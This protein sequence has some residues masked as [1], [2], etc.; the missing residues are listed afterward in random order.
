VV[1]A[2]SVR[3][4]CDEP[5]CGYDDW[6]GAAVVWPSWAAYSTNIRAGYN[7]RRTFDEVGNEVF[8]YMGA[9][10]DGCEVTAVEGITLIIEWERGSETWRETYLQPGDT[11][12]I[13]LVGNENNAMIETIDGY[14][15]FS[16]SL[17]NCDPQPLPG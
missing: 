1:D 9:W 15:P 10:A 5:G 4:R 2:V 17:E 14:P 11:Y 8:P 16:V 6:L 3:W 12:V 7:S 13:D